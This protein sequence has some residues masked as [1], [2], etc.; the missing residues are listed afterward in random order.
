[1]RLFFG[2]AFERACCEHHFYLL[3][4]KVNVAYIQK[5]AGVTGLSKIGAGDRDFKRTGHRFR[6]GLTTPDCRK[7]LCLN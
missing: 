4:V 1:M 6:R 7:L 5:M 3:L 2:G